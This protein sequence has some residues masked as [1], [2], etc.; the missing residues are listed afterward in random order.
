MVP[1]SCKGSII[2]PPPR[3]IPPSLAAD[4]RENRF[5]YGELVERIKIE[6]AS[7]YS[8]VALGLLAFQSIDAVIDEDADE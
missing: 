4:R 7:L 6:H 5:S 8:V 2:N 3:P 1:F